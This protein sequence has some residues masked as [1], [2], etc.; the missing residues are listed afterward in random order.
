[1]IF[2]RA[3]A[4]HLS[5]FSNF[6]LGKNGTRPENFAS[7]KPWCHNTN[8]RCIRIFIIFFSKTAEQN[9]NLRL[10]YTFAFPS[11][12]KYAKCSDNRCVCMGANCHSRAKN[13]WSVASCCVANSCR[14]S[15]LVK[16]SFQE[17]CLWCHSF[18][19]CFQISWKRP[20]T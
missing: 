13:S 19:A 5:E 8:I 3:G 11:S 15:G 14:C 10:S 4:G 9:Y 1:M 12:W 18:K 6:I 17:R 16:V 7:Y 2:S 20:V